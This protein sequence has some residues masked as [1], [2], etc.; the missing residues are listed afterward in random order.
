M[1]ANTDLAENA[2]ALEGNG[3]TQKRKGVRVPPASSVELME[4]STVPTTLNPAMRGFLDV[5][6]RLIVRDLLQEAGR[7]YHDADN[8]QNTLCA[9]NP[10][11]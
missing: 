3:D 7:S 11:C 2:A 5:V 4:A 8:S 6:A 9:E 10:V 1:L